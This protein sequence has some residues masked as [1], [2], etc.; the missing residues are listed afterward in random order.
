MSKYI[1]YRKQVVDTI[2]EV[3]RE[4]LIDQLYNFLGTDVLP[5]TPIDPVEVNEKYGTV[6][7][8][9]TNAKITIAKER[10]NSLEA[11]VHFGSDPVSKGYAVIQHE[12][13]VYKHNYPTDYKFLENPFE[14]NYSDLVDAVAV[15]IRML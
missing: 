1:S 7:E 6:A 4:A 5:V 14:S 15:S 2:F 10:N 9:R 13:E 12:N 8:L 11:Y 3:S